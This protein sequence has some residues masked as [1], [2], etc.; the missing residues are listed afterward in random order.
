MSATSSCFDNI[1]GLSRTD[2]PCV[3]DR[4]EGANVSESGLFLDELPGL[5]LRLINAT[6]DCG[7]EGIWSKMER[8]VENAIDETVTELMACIAANTDPARPIGASQIGE[9]KKATQSAHTL[10]HAYH[11]LTVQTAYVRG[12]TFRITAIGTAMKATSGMPDTITVHVYDRYENGGNDPIAT[13]VL[14]IAGGRSVWTEIDGLALDMEHLGSLHPRYYL[15]FEPYA[16]AQAMNA[17]ISCNCGGYKPYW[18]ANAPQYMGR[19]S[20]G[21]APWTFWAMAGGTYGATLDNRDE[22]AVENPTSGLM[23]RVAFECDERS[24][25][26][27]GA[28]NYQTDHVQKVLAHTVRFKAGANLLTDLVRSTDINRWTMT[29]GDGLEAQKKEYLDNWEKRLKEYLCPELSS[30]ASINRYGDCRKCKDTHG[31]RRS[32]I[33]N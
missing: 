8:A 2:C 24:S 9:D 1:I 25:F 23:I 29:D 17:A 30:M 7:S 10:R 21:A 4:P 22:W 11:G 20:N 26:C 15:L 14:P 16:G 33:P 19:P 12:G 13:Y 32:K 18:D 5:N 27:L 28:P 31:L 3:E 6:Q